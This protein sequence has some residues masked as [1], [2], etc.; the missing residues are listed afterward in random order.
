MNTVKE[1]K[2]AIKAMDAITKKLMPLQSEQEYWQTILQNLD[3]LDRLA[4]EEAEE[5]EP[6]SMPDAVAD[7]API[8]EEEPQ[9]PGIKGRLGK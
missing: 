7:S 2:R 4:A 6:E 9:L 5:G 1:R 8:I 3:E